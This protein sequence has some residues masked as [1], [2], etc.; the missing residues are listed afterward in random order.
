MFEYKP[1][2][3]D[4]CDQDNDP[5]SYMKTKNFLTTETTIVCRKNCI[6]DIQKFIS[7]LL[8]KQKVMEPTQTYTISYRAIF[9]WV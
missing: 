1:P 2:V 6:R 7:L 5:S 9:F 3:A 8:C 4:S